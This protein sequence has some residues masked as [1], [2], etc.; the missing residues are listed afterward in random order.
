MLTAIFI[1]TTIICAKG[2]VKQTIYADT[3][4]VYFVRKGYPKPKAE[5][6]EECVSLALRIMLRRRRR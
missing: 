1:I 5:D 3:L 6:L 4:M 2:W